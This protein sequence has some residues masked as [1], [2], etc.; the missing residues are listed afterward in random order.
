[1]KR[2][3]RTARLASASRGRTWG[4]ELGAGA[5]LDEEDVGFRFGDHVFRPGEYVSVWEP[6]GELVTFKVVSIG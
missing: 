1:L 5:R 2:R 4:F 6:E 3:A